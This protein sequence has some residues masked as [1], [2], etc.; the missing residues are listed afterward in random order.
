MKRNERRRSKKKRSS[1]VEAIEDLAFAVDVTGAPLTSHSNRYRQYIT[2][3]RI[4][5][6]T[7]QQKISPNHKHTEKNG[8]EG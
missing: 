3:I 5:N 8:G 1:P 2:L 6:T 4:G 7:K